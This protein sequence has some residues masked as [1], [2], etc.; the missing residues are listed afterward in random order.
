MNRIDIDYVCVCCIVCVFVFISTCTSYILNR[1]PLIDS[2]GGVTYHQRPCRSPASPFHLQ[3]H[4]TFEP[5]HDVVHYAIIPTIHVGPLLKD[6][7]VLGTR[8]IPYVHRG[9]NSTTAR[10]VPA[11]TELEP[12]ALLRVSN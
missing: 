6:D 5:V 1:H 9:T 11:R 12:A 8:V 2:I 10:E 3:R 4:L 7:L